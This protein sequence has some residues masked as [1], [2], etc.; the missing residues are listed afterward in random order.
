[1]NPDTYQRDLDD[2][3]HTQPPKTSVVYVIGQRD[4]GV[5]KIGVTT[6]LR[7][8]LKMLQTGSPVPLEVLW[9]HPGYGDLEGALH[10]LLDYCRLE[11]E[12]FNLAGMDPVPFV[13]DIVREM[14]P[15]QFTT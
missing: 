9:W 2:Y 4:T 15:D 14:H 10:D 7:A 6:S 11:G 8:R 1:M 13:A 12:W 5:V 3:L